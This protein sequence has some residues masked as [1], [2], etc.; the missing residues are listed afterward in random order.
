MSIRVL[1]VDDHQLFRHGMLKML[2]SFKDVEVVGE[3]ESGEEAISRAEEIFPDVIIMDLGLPGKIDGIEA[4]HKI[5]RLYPKV[6]IVALTMYQDEKHILMA[7]KAGASGYVVKDAK[8][9]EVVE[10]VRRAKRGESLLDPV[11][12]RKILNEFTSMKTNLERDKIGFDDLTSREH[13]ILK[14]I[15]EGKANKEIAYELNVSEKTI[16]NHITNIFR[17]MQVNARTEAA[18]K[19]IKLGLIDIDD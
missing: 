2:E 15:A 5:K 17:K 4:T 6:E 16:K 19:A 9:E 3:A 11:V 18:V 12:S 14:I 1:I 10:A 7:I 13:Q 8:I